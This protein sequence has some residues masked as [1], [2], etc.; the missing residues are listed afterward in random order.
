MLTLLEDC[1]GN[2]IPVGPNANLTVTGG[3]EPYFRYGCQKYIVGH[4]IENNHE[5]RSCPAAYINKQQLQSNFK[6]AAPFKDSV[7]K[8]GEI[9][10]LLQKLMCVC[11]PCGIREDTK[12]MVL[13]EWSECLLVCVCGRET[14]TLR[15][16]VAGWSGIKKTVLCRAP[17]ATGISM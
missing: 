14:H 16:Q 7:S 2:G 1:T 10:V 5:N 17:Q 11:F 3:F 4:K 9:I 8:T 15:Q 13:C 12:S 6:R